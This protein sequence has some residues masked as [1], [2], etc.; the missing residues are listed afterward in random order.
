MTALPG[1]DNSPACGLLFEKLA[2]VHCGAMSSL[3]LDTTHDTD[4]GKVELLEAERVPYPEA[5]R[6]AD[7]HPRWRIKLSIKHK[8]GTQIRQRQGIGPGWLVKCLDEHWLPF[9]LFPE[10]PPTDEYGMARKAN[11]SLREHVRQVERVIAQLSL[12]Q[13]QF[14]AQQVVGRDNSAPYYRCFFENPTPSNFYLCER[15]YGLW[16]RGALQSPNFTKYVASLRKR[17][18]KMY[19]TPM[20]RRPQRQRPPMNLNENPSPDELRA[21]L[22]DLDDDEGPHVPWV[23]FNGVVHIDPVPDHQHPNEFARARENE[24]KLR[25]GSLAKFQRYVGPSA[26]AD[27][28]WVDRLF[29]ELLQ[30]WHDDVDGFHGAQDWH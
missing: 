19:H 24:M 3:L 21:I 30:L 23:G 2:R 17:G 26:A 29:N 16:T 28:A 5:L 12:W 6:V 25:L 1:V 15:V 20:V 11:G 18:I 13:W 10:D 7:Q 22:F 9:N 8:Y 4:W 14:L 27:E